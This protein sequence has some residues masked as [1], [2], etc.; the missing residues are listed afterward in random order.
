L[1]YQ[2]L[3]DTEFDIMNLIWDSEPPVTTSTVMDTLGRARGW[4]PQT[5]VTLFGRLVSRGFLAVKKGRGRSHQ[6]RPLIS[7]QD[8]LQMETNAFFDRYHGRSLGSLI[9]S[10]NDGE[11]TRDDIEELQSLIRQ[12][13]EGGERHG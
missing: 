12:A 1:T 4:K 9:A 3:P 5:V 6:Y 7:R 11:L 13:K 2:R 10:L 8:Y